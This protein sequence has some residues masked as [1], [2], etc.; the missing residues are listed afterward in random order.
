MSPM[1]RKW[2]Y[3]EHSG[4]PATDPRMTSEAVLNF[5]FKTPDKTLRSKMEV[6]LTFSAT[7]LT[8]RWLRSV[9]NASRTKPSRLSWGGTSSIQWRFG[10]WVSCLGS[11]DAWT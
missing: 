10:F 4:D 6:F 9:S 2:P 11:L 5:M 1:Q 8:T 7:A 3:K